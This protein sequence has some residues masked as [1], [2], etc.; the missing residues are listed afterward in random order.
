MAPNV[1]LFVDRLLWAE[2]SGLRTP[3]KRW[4]VVFFCSPG[5][6][7]FKSTVRESFLRIIVTTDGLLSSAIATVKGRLNRAS[8]KLSLFPFLSLGR[9]RTKADSPIF[10]FECCMFL[11]VNKTE[12]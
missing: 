3:A 7:F 5:V 11:L 9:L 12:V 2:R 10:S 4:L 6:G 8:L 1:D